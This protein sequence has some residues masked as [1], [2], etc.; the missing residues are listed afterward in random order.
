MSIRDEEE[1]KADFSI[2]MSYNRSSS[3]KEPS[4]LL[5]LEM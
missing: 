1:T 4:S 3:G 5:V 2:A